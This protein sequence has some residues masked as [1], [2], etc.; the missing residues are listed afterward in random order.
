MK[1]IFLVATLVALQL[2]AQTS[3]DNSAGGV[4]KPYQHRLICKAM[5]QN[6]EFEL[7][8]K[9]K[10][11]V[12][13][14][15]PDQPR[16]APFIDQGFKYELKNLLTNEAWSGNYAS[17]I[18]TKAVILDLP[19]NLKLSGLFQMYKRIGKINKTDEI[20]FEKQNSK[21]HLA[22]MTL[23]SM[24]TF[25]DKD[26]CEKPISKLCGSEPTG[27]SQNVDLWFE[28]SSCEYISLE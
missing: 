13:F 19:E 11:K 4:E 7:N 27:S 24:E 15:Q 25:T 20:F 18:Y 16:R 28:S 21:I 14:D 9:W 12:K 1:T 23:T 17:S 3:V 26:C 2:K 10:N 22:H 6:Q 5:S 8:V